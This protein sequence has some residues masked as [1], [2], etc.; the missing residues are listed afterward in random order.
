MMRTLS[1]RILANEYAP[2][3][4]LNDDHGWIDP[5]GKFW[6]VPLHGHE[7]FAHWWYESNKETPPKN[8][9]AVQ[10]L[11]ERGWIHISYGT[12]VIKK[13]P[14][15]RQTDTVY[16]WMQAR[17]G[18]AD[19]YG[20]YGNTNMSANTFLEQHAKSIKNVITSDDKILKKIRTEMTDRSGDDAWS[21]LDLKELYKWVG[22]FD[23]VDEACAWLEADSVMP[24]H[25]DPD[26]E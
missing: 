19:F 7:A 8:R 24:K 26:L 5:S 9:P 3:D 13:K 11:E 20:F 2:S 15:N 23:T 6:P 25:I 17:G 14:N 16:D 4:N 10:G 22:S 12:V 1:K 18:K 21:K